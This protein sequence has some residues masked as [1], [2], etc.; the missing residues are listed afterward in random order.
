MTSSPGMT[1]CGS[2]ARSAVA[3][4]LAMNAAAASDA[5]TLGVAAA[6]MVGQRS[7][8]ERAK[9]TFVRSLLYRGVRQIHF[10]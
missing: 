6:A 7:V 3:D 2:N 5:D 4:R 1:L 8:G 10:Y 9:M